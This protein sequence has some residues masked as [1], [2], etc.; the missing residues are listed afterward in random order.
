[1]AAIGVLG[2]FFKC[3][4]APYETAFMLHDLLS[5]RGV[6]DAVTIY[7]ASPLGKPI[8]ISDETSNAIVSLLVERGIAY[9]PSSLVTRLD[10]AAKVVACFQDGRKLAYDLFLGIS[11]HRA[12]AVVVESAASPAQRSAAGRGQ[13]GQ[14][15]C[16]ATCSSLGRLTFDTG[17]LTQ[18]AGFR[19]EVI[20]HELLHLRVPNH[21]PV[22]RALFRAHRGQHHKQ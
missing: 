13:T 9:W 22:F 21:G 19:D 4:P 6:R 15:R 11:I 3:P 18:P 7:V 8:P 16:A 17:L 5:R 2:G 20:T 1:V 10:P 12:P 14:T